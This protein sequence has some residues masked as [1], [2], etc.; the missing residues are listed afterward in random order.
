MKRRE[1]REP[2]SRDLVLLLGEA[3]RCAQQ[4]IDKASEFLNPEFK[5]LSTEEMGEILRSDAQQREAAREF[6]GLS[7]DLRAVVRGV[8]NPDEE[9]NQWLLSQVPKTA[10]EENESRI[11]NLTFEEAT[12]QEWCRHKTRE[13][14]VKFMDRAGYPEGFIA[15]DKITKEAYQKAAEINKEAKRS[16]DAQSKKRKR[17]ANQV[18]EPNKRNRSRT[19]SPKKRTFGANSRTKSANSRTF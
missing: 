4:F 8:E 17:R 3:V 14:L 16:R 15:S 10:A 11:A 1:H 7:H 6:W 12:K 5:D 13:N 9:I 2:L 18:S 19:K